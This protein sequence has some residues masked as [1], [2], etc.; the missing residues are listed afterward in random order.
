MT[1]TKR[2]AV[3]Y[4]GNQLTTSSVRPR[5]SGCLLNCV[6]GICRENTQLPMFAAQRH[7]RRCCFWLCFLGLWQTDTWQMGKHLLILAL[8]LS[9]QIVPFKK[10]IGLSPML[11]LVKNSENKQMKIL[12]ITI[13]FFCKALHSFS[14]FP[15][16]VLVSATV[17]FKAIM[18]HCTK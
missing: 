10:Y 9:G 1:Y 17:Y 13:N 18:A 15:P 5:I 4:F 6:A 14:L 12:L 2:N 7:V 3:N 11:W 16:I 8:Q